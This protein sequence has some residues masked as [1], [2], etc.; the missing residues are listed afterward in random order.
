MEH[1]NGT[2]TT[3]NGLKRQK[4]AENVTS[5]LTR[6]T[7]PSKEKG[8]RKKN[9]NLIKRGRGIYFGGRDQKVEDK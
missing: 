9:G 4:S 8:E 7:T 5:D 2:I 6:L 3:N 1:E